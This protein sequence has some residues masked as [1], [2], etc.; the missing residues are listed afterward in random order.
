MTARQ[1][2][3]MTSTS[4]Y[5]E[6]SSAKLLPQ[7]RAKMEDVYKVPVVEDYGATETGVLAVMGLDQSGP[8]AGSVGKPAP[9]V[10]VMDEEGHEMPPFDKG[11]VCIRGPDVITGF[12][13]NPEANQLQFRDGWYRTGD[14]GYVDAAGYLFVTGRFSENISRGGEQ[15]APLEVDQVLIGHPEVLNAAAFGVSDDLLG[16]EVWAVVVPAHESAADTAE[17]R[18]YASRFLPFAKV[19]KRVIRVKEIPHNAIGKV[20]R[21]DLTERYSS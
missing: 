6:S 21:A 11:E 1:S 7:L 2:L 14:E 16:Q 5:V 13:N 18:K 9:G 10:V 19:P 8:A 17:I 12:E 15:I 4:G 3:S 20:A